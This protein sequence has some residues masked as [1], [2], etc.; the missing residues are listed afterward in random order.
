MAK[1][2]EL[3]SKQSEKKKEVDKITDIEKRVNEEIQLK[4]ISTEY[5]C[6]RNKVLEMQR[7]AK[8]EYFNSLI[9]NSKNTAT[10]WR[11]MNEILNVS[12]NQIDL[13]HQVYPRMSI[14]ITFCL[15]L[16]HFGKI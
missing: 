11:A 14:T 6:Q 8:K 13:K 5:K 1:R 16:H 12:K 2:D 15:L 4:N 3:K 10:I 9:E 7:K